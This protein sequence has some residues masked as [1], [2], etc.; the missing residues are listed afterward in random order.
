MQLNKHHLAGVLAAAGALLAC[1]GLVT[2]A[3]TSSVATPSHLEKAAGP[4][5]AIPPEIATIYS[6]IL[7]TTTKYV[8][9]DLAPASP[10]GP[11]AFTVVKRALD[12]DVSADQAAAWQ[13]MV[14]Q[15]PENNCRYG[16][17]DFT[18]ANEAGRR[19]DKVVLVTSRTCVGSPREQMDIV[20][21]KQD[22]LNRFPTIDVEFLV[23]VRVAARTRPHTQCL[24]ARKCSPSP[25]PPPPVRLLALH[26]A[27][28]AK[29]P[30]DLD[31]WMARQRV[32][33]C[34]LRDE[35]CVGSATF[36]NPPEAAGS[37]AR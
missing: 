4:R 37:H 24:C 22:L 14:D 5:F 10:G 15:L 36:F 1:V 17:F 28:Q 25:R 21:G 31:Y 7:H 19:V 3:S 26:G 12:A 34:V 13:H 18:T 33:A 32:E 23:R 30:A 29:F 6:G 16:I 27:P 20:Y 35:G 8:V 11:L 2:L 9:L